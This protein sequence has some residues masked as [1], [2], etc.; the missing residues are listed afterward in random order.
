MTTPA[1]SVLVTVYNREKYLVECL[2]SIRVSTYHDFEVIV[3]DDRSSDRSPEIAS[4]FASKDSRFS[5]RQNAANL[6]DYGN[7]MQAARIA[8]GR[9]IKYV[10][11]DDVIYPHG[12]AVMVNA[13]ETNP[14]AALGLS[15]SL[16]EDE[17]PYP[18]LFSPHDAYRKEF[19]GDGCMGSGPTGAIIRR[20][21]FM[22][23]GGFES[24]GVLS[25]TECWYRLSARWPI[26]LLPPGLVW[27]RRHEGQEFTR[28]DADL[29]YL[30]KGLAVAMKALHSPECPLD[31]SERKRAK[32]RI[33]HRYSRRLMSAAI[34]GPK[35]RAAVE[36]M[37]KS[38]LS[39][40]ELIGA[41]RPH[42]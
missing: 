17:S 5:F 9:Y 1:V 33:R 30:E 36:A 28:G 31:A 7:R 26:L 16:P 37:R 8:V 4:R 41:F 21:A 13:M 38:G 35:R 39:T 42:W 23:A 34:K 3:V 6:G 11:A 12:L 40:A 2:E 22:E 20:D 15:H 19:L 24:W 27:W 10:D 32:E 18:W 14:D 29:V 25:D